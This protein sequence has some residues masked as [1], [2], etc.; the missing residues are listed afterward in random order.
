VAE[1][2]PFRTVDELAALVGGYCWQEGRLFAL[3]GYWAGYDSGA[4]ALNVCFNEM[5]SRHG[6]HAARWR[7]RLPVRAGVAADALVVAPPGWAAALDALADQPDPLLALAGLVE[8]ALPRLRAG[9]RDH[10]VGAAAVREAPV[11]DVLQRVGASQDGEIAE[12][13]ALLQQELR[14]AD[15][16]DKATENMADFGQELQRLFEGASRVFP[17]ARAS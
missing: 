8:V 1:A 13:A 14:R 17:A 9:Y 10:L 5:S 15:P 12:A 4:P 2:V 11:I 7:D 3:T 6:A 16:A